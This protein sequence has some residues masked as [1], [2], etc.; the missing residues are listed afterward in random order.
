[1]YKSHFTN[2]CNKKGNYAQSLSGSVAQRQESVRDYKR[3]ES[4]NLKREM[5]ILIKKNEK[6]KQWKKKYTN[7]KDDSSISSKDSNNSY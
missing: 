7:K 4:K 2:Q 5:K 6:L 1:V 3:N